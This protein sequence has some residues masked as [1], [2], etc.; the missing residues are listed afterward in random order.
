[1]ALARRL[2]GDPHGPADDHSGGL[3]TAP[4][5]YELFAALAFLGRRR[6]V[7]DRLVARAGI[8]AGDRVLDIGCGTGYL[9]RRAAAVAGSVVGVDPSINVIEYARRK[10]PPTCVFHVAEGRRVPE[11]DAS[12]DVAVSSLALHHIEP[13][14]R[15]DTFAEI[16]RLLCPGGRL[17]I[18]DFRPPSGAL[19]NRFVGAVAGHAM[20][21]TQV[22]D[23]A[24]AITAAGFTVVGEGDLRPFL[25]YVRALVQ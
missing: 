1:M 6:A 18:A 21:H 13:G 14:Q 20:Q 3:I 4:K 11:E 17:L 25:H 12:F 5:R 24:P 22:E 15:A 23:H 8:T 9:T 19:G 2:M 10:S 16:F 7:F